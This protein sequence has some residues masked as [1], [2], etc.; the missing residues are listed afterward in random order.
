MFNYT[1]DCQSLSMI[2]VEDT[3]LKFL[4]HKKENRAKLSHISETEY[5]E[6]E[7]VKYEFVDCE[8]EICTK[9]CNEYASWVET[10]W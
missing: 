3:H 9:E 4:L 2:C 6:K 10:G 7:V 5:I 8:I 1:L